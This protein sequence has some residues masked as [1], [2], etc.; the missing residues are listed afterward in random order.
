MKTKKNI[1]FVM[2]NLNGGGAE[3]V[4]V[5]IINNLNFEKFNIDLF[6]VKKQGIY[7]ENIDKRVNIFSAIDGQ[8][9]IYSKIIEKVLIKYFPGFFYK[10][11]IRKKYD[12]EVGFLEGIPTKIVAA[13]KGKSKKIAWVHIDL[14]KKHWTK[15][16]FKSGEEELVYNKMDKIV[17]VSEEAKKSFNKVFN[18]R[19]LQEV[20]YNPIINEG[21]LEKA[22]E[23][24]IKFDKFTIVSVGRLNYQ[25]GYDMLIEAHSKLI[26]KHNY[27]LLIIGEGPEK[28]SLNKLINDLKLNDSVVLKGFES[29]PYKFVRAAD[30]Y[31]SSS[32]TEGYPLA[33]L[34]AI[35]LKKAIVATDVTGNREI[36]DN[37]KYGVLCRDDAKSLEE[38]I[39]NILSNTVKI[40]ELEK[41]ATIKMQ[42]MDYRK[43]ILQIEK[44]LR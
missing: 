14:L 27:N 23:E 5:D 10:L 12:V 4:L 21:I 33:L 37:G 28:E 16:F 31:V 2:N 24:N 30:L 13:S 17:F 42:Q 7:L 32:R 26:K 1:L 29:N 15:Q 20:I 35:V 39:D 36:L 40:N 38:S 9:K 18:N 43:I 25:K 6:L 8:N 3:K 34:E 11:N 44:V 22:C 41:L 19:S